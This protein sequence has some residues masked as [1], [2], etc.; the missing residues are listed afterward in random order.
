ML[1]SNHHLIKEGIK[2][3]TEINILLDDIRDDYL[4]WTNQVQK[5]KDFPPHVKR[6]VEDFNE[7]L[8]YKIGRKYVKII[9]KHSVWGFVAKY[10]FKH[11]KAG[12]I[13]KAA[14]YNAP[15]LNQA[16]GNIFGSYSIMW[17]GPRYLK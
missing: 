15:A 7:T 12:D 8:T 6:M 16:R 13:L 11:F 17:T 14:G 3:I 9:Q 4:S 5:G 10:D 2:M 1:I